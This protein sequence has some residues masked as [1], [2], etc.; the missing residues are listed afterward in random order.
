TVDH[1]LR[2]AAAAEACWVAA[3]AARLGFAHRTLRWRRAPGRRAT[4]AGARDAR[5]RLLEDAAAERGC[6][7]LLLGHH[8]DDNAR[9]VAMRRRRAEGP[10]L[11]GMPAVR[12]LDRVRV[13]RPLLG[14]A[15][16]RL[17]ATAARPGYGWI[18]DP[19]NRDPRF[20][21]TR[22]AASAV[23][24][25]VEERRALETA[26]RAWLARHLHREAGGAL[27]FDAAA[28]DRA[29]RGLAAEVLARAVATVGG[30]TPAPGRG[31]V[32]AAVRRLDAGRTRLTLAGALVGR[33]R[34]RLVVAPERST[35]QSPASKQTALAGAGFGGSHVVSD[36]AILIC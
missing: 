5:Y 23:A 24:P 7:H 20:E 32:A 36:A 14:F 19:A 26:A 22:V 31:R 3:A 35:L 13:L 27:A 12:E 8:R 21:R 18:E 1:G 29:P 30:T 4:Q 6:L 28:W 17:R 34:E 11:A 10:G 2:A 33:A 16:A 15:R 25:A 9:T